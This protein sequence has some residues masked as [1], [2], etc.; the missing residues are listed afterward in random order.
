MKE[1]LEKLKTIPKG[2]IKQVAEIGFLIAECWNEF[3]FSDDGGMETYKLQGRIEN[4]NWDPPILSFI[5]ERHGGIVLGSTRAEIQK[6]ELNTEKRTAL[7][8][9]TGYRQIKPKQKNLDVKL[10]AE[11]TAKL[12]VN[13]EKHERLRWSEDGSVYVQIGKIIPEDSSFKE[14]V[15]NRRKRFRTQLDEILEKKDWQKLSNNHYKKANSEY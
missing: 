6:W 15:V 12:I 10:I 5:I 14:T 9:N 4:L 7:F 8:S 11:D 13:K 2:P 1:L 3:S